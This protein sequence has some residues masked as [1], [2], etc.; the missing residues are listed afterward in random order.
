MGGGKA[1]Q[2]DF[3]LMLMCVSQGC[4]LLFALVPCPWPPRSRPSASQPH[5]FVT[6]CVYELLTRISS[7]LSPT[8]RWDLRL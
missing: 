5:A 2:T 1:A 6:C 4:C 3:R 8:V 7:I